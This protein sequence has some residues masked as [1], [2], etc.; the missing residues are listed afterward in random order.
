MLADSGYEYFDDDTSTT[1]T[2]TTDDDAPSGPPSGPPPGGRRLQSDDPLSTA[3][4]IAL[5][6]VQ[7]YNALDGDNTDAI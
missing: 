5:S 4:G 2:T 3:S 6:G 7:I 1:T